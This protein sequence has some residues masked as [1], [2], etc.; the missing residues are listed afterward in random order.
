VG[1][2]AAEGSGTEGMRAR[3]RE[4][5]GALDRD[6]RRGMLIRLTAPWTPPASGTA[7]LREVGA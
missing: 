6:G 1:G 4:I 2:P 3:A 5:G 7:E